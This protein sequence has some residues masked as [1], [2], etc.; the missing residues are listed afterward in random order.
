M[1][2]ELMQLFLFIV[3]YSASSKSCEDFM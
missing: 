2:I 3:P 1:K